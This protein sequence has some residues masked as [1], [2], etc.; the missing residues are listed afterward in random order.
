M[1]VV[2]QSVSSET[3]FENLP[4]AEEKNELNK[5]KTYIC[6]DILSNNVYIFKG[7]FSKESSVLTYV[8]EI[9]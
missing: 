8:Y 6:A 9:L 4:V 3:K 7:E 2:A 5:G 1:K